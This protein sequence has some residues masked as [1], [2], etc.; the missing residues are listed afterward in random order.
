MIIFG[1]GISP[2]PRGGN[3]AVTISMII[4]RL[5]V[6]EREREDLSRRSTCNPM[7]TPAQ[8]TGIFIFDPRGGVLEYVDNN[9]RYKRMTV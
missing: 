8:I 7:S 3:S 9:P 4:V 1:S 5:N 2:F 6:V